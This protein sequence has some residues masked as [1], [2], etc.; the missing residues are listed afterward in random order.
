MTFVLDL[1]LFYGEKFTKK[2]QKKPDEAILT[3]PSMAP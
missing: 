3:F 1:N 2:G